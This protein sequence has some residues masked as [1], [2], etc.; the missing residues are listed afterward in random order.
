MR[1]RH[2]YFSLTKGTLVATVHEAWIDGIMRVDVTSIVG[3]LALIAT[4]SPNYSLAEIVQ[5]STPQKASLAGLITRDL[6]SVKFPRNSWDARSKSFVLLAEFFQN[7]W[8]SQLTLNTPPREKAEI[9]REIGYLHSL[10][11][12]REE[13]RAEIAEEDDDM[14]HGY[15][16]SLMMNERT[17]PRTFE[18]MNF[19]QLLGGTL[20]LYFKAQFERPRPSQLAPDLRPILAVPGNASYPG[21]HAAQ[22]HLISFVLAELRP[23]AKHILL[24][25]A[26]RISHN[27]EV[28]GLHYPS[29]TIA[30]ESLAK[31]ANELAKSGE[32]FRQLMINAK[33]E[34]Q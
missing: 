26:R 12:L 16:S 5:K 6:N 32:Q 25:L 33:A 20:V 27:R 11:R 29:D 9:E 10:K 3:F 17:Y 34:W 23:D 28:A 15:F 19:A 13:R 2:V 21:G 24:E 8:H 7:D 4:V 22:S 31:Q 14:F 1:G 30:G 18:L